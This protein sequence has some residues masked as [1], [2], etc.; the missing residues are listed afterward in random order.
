MHSTLTK[1]KT[2]KKNPNNIE[3]YVRSELKCIDEMQ[4]REEIKVDYLKRQ[5]LSK[6]D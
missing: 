2:E 5:I 3:Y 6:A 4:M 1:Q